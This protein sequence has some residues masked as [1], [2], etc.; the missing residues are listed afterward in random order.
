LNC[1]AIGSLSPVA[2]EIS[3]INYDAEWISVGLVISVYCE[4]LIDLVSTRL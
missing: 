2:F 4:N 1:A 3:R